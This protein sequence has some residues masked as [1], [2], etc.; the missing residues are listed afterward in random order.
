MLL[1]S[2]LLLWLTCRPHAVTR[3]LLMFARCGLITARRIVPPL[4]MHVRSGKRFLLRLVPLGPVQLAI[5]VWRQIVVPLSV[6][7]GRWP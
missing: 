1:P 6:R 4:T 3:T 7:I 5:A 2:V